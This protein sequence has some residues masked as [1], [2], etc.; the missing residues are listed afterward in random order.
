MAKL[1]AMYRH[2]KDTGAFDRYYFNT[3]APIAKRLPGLLGYEVTR[4]TV[5]TL[6]PEGSPYYL[7]AT[8][9]FASVEAIRA[10]LASPEGQTTAGDLAN[11]AQA[12]VDLFFAESEAI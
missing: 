5:H 6:A 3:H 1:L 7:I 8:L 4:G 9:T 12:G 10:A 11:F 2:P